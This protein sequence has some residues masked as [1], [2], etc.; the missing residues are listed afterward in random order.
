MYVKVLKQDAQRVFATKFTSAYCQ[1]FWFNLNR[2]VP[3]I[4]WIALTYYIA[5]LLYCYDSAF[6]LQ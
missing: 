6:V 2:I 4:Y 1:D 3:F 5:L